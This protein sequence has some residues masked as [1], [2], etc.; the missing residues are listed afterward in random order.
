MSNQTWNAAQSYERSHDSGLMLPNVVC[1]VTL[2][3]SV[4]CM[5]PWSSVAQFQF[6]EDP[7][8]QIVD[9][10]AIKDTPPVCTSRTTNCIAQPWT[11]TFCHPRATV[12]LWNEELWTPQ[13]PHSTNPSNTHPCYSLVS[14]RTSTC[15]ALPATC[16]NAL[17]FK[18][19]R[20]EIGHFQPCPQTSPGLLCELTHST[21]GLLCSHLTYMRSLPLQRKMIGIHFDA[22][23]YLSFLS[24]GPKD[25]TMQQ[26]PQIYI[27]TSFVSLKHCIIPQPRI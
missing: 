5:I 23:V 27:R 13:L 9:L 17:F 2:L 3:Q 22:A 8:T 10:L 11:R 16:W 14:M 18:F 1:K 21:D 7:V 4:M 20:R 12:T 6:G 15:T 19:G 25:D 24:E 26:G